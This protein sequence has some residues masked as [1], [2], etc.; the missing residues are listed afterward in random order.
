MRE[1]SRPPLRFGLWYDFRNPPAWKRPYD[2]L[3]GEILDQI[4]WADQHGFD[5]VWLS[6]HHFLGIGPLK[7]I[8]EQYVSA[9][10]RLAKPTTNLR[11]AGGYFWL[12]PA[13]DPEKTWHEA[14]D[15]VL[16]QLNGY[17]EWFEK[18]GMPIFPRV[19]DQAHLRELE[20]LNV[21]DVDTCI[22]MIRAYAAEVPLS[23][24]YS[25]VLPPGLPASWAQPHLE[26]FASQV[27]PAFR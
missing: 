17:A 24:Y 5:D 12:I 18:A 4:V 20:M 19:R 26:L 2:H 27:I 8:Y 21:V 13:T 14:A 10:Q 1:D 11:L 23:H 16:Y 3:Y 25:S 15:H 22:Q 7:G 9:L 6:E